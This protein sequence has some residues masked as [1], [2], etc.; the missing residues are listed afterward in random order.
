MFQAP[1]QE[2]PTII[3]QQKIPEVCSTQLLITPSPIVNLNRIGFLNEITKKIKFL[4]PFGGVQ[5]LVP[6]DAFKSKYSTCSLSLRKIKKP[7]ALLAILLKIFL[8]VI[9]Y[10]FP[11]A[12]GF[13][14]VKSAVVMYQNDQN[15][16]TAAMQFQMNVREKR[17][18][19]LQKTIID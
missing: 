8:F 18:R 2:R 6:Y 1:P 11:A 3:I 13:I 12:L 9:I 4:I 7:A 10:F 19:Y 15:C 16:K 14:N 5:C 17:L